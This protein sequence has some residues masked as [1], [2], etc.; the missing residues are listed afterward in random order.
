MSDR[1][2]DPEGFRERVFEEAFHLLQ[3]GEQPKVE[4]KR[5]PPSIPQLAKVIAAIANT[6]D[7]EAGYY[8]NEALRDHGFLIIGVEGG[9]V[10]GYES[11]ESLGCGA[12]EEKVKD[13]LAQKLKEYIA[14]LPK[15][16]LYRFEDPKKGRTFW[17]VLI[18]PSK[19]QPH[20][21]IKD[22]SEVERLTVYVRKS[23][24]TE[25]AHADDY[26]RFLRKA[27]APLQTLQS[28]VKDLERRL[29]S[30]EDRLLQVE[31]RLGVILNKL[32]EVGLSALSSEK[33]LT[34][35]GLSA[36]P[37]TE[38]SSSTEEL[39]KG[40]SLKAFG[41]A[42][43]WKSLEELAR[44]WGLQQEDPIEKALRNEIDGLRKHL[45]SLP[46]NLSGGTHE[47]KAI[48]DDLQEKTLPLLRGLGELVRADKEE[49]YAPSVG[50][51]LERLALAPVVPSNVNVLTPDAESFR[52]YPLLLTAYHLGM[53]A[54]F[55]GR[56]NYLRLLLTTR[57]PERRALGGNR[58]SNL[59]PEVRN[60]FYLA[61]HPLFENLYPRHCEPLGW[62]LYN[63]LFIDPAP[64]WLALPPKVREEASLHPWPSDP[65]GTQAIYVEGEFV[66]GLLA[67]KPHLSEAHG[68]TRPFPGLL[69]LYILEFS[70][71]SRVEALVADPPAHLCQVL[72]L[73][74]GNLGRYLEVLSSRIPATMST[75]SGGICF[76]ASGSF[77][78]LLDRLGSCP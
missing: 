33:K 73:S 10:E 2:L 54:H 16:S 27:V 17:V 63:F 50:E 65:T 40:W 42:S 52:L 4:F 43:S 3:R 15:F 69:G 60:R 7:P 70:N 67:L 57:L 8:T 6:D 34:K 47:L 26:A 13:C 44:S 51:A 37:S 23:S 1:P 12:E 32:I 18:Y 74:G 31:K 53:L 48:L 75:A 66:L 30:L 9:E 41:L 56:P 71:L 28:Q 38:E 64:T 35:R 72:E 24:V 25:K 36:L 14:P 77:K 78:R 68:N 46:W 45:D 76:S 5:E 22:G 29:E 58:T 11:W 55:H 19:E 59:L 21:V 39:S 61:I 62:H 20:L 49:K